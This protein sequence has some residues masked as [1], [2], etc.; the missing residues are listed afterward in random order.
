MSDTRVLVEHLE[1]IRLSEKATEDTSA[2]YTINV[3]ISERTRD[4][5]TLSLNFEL[6]LVAE[7][8]IAKL[9]VGG[10]STIAGTREEIQTAIRPADSKSPPPILFTIYERVYGLLYLISR[11]L[12]IPHPMPGLARTGSEVG[13]EAR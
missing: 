5:T 12:K 8:Q 11:D 2:T 4:P 6:D 10:V 3:S 9:I 13:K 7:P 1:A